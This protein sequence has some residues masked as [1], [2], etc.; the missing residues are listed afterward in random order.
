MC[1]PVSMS[2]VDF[3]QYLQSNSL[4]DPANAPVM[5]LCKNHSGADV[6]IHL[7]Q[8]YWNYVDWLEQRGDIDFTAWV[9]HCEATPF[10]DWPISQLLMYWLWRDNCR[11]HRNGDPTF[12]DAPPDGYEPYGERANDG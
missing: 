1:Y 7:P 11:R 12:S 9:D 5:R 10:E 8:G 4:K 3:M 6:M 2:Q